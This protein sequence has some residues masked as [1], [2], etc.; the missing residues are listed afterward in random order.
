VG[1]R[2]LDRPVVG[3]TLVHGVRPQAFR[4]TIP[5]LRNRTI[6]I[7][8]RTALGSVVA[9]TEILGPTSSAMSNSRNPSPLMLGAAAISRWLIASSWPIVLAGVLRQNPAGGQWLISQ[10]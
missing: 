5:P 8:K 1:G 6:A 4:L 2:A 9:V 3:Q 10:L 7:T